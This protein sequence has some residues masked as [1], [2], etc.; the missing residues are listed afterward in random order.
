[1]NKTKILGLSSDMGGLW[2]SVPRQLGEVD[3]F[4][5]IMM[6]PNIYD[7]KVGDIMVMLGIIKLPN[8]YHIKLN[9][10]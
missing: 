3:E 5:E 2:G 6:N 10:S 9:E 7:E 4:F 8:S 1:M